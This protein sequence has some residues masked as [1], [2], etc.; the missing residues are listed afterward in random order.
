MTAL[1]EKLDEK[2]ATWNRETAS[3][4]E[5][6]VGEII[7]LADND[8]LDIVPSRAVVQEVL[9]ILDED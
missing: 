7:E 1:A 3:E 4:V 9:D 2:L 5:R 6:M 8:V